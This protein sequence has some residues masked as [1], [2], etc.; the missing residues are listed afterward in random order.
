MQTEN[1]KEK[2][3]KIRLPDRLSVYT[4]DACLGFDASERVETGDILVSLDI[5]RDALSVFVSADKT[6][7]KYIKL[8]WNL[9]E[10]E[11]RR[12]SL[13]VLG[14]SWERA[15]G[16]LEWHS[17]NPERCLPF[18]FLVSNGS[19]QERDCLGRFTEGFG[20]KVQAGAMCFWN[21]DGS[22]ITLW[23]DVRCGGDGVILGGR[24]LHASDIVFGEYRDMSAYEA[25]EHFCH[26]MSP[27]TLTPPH[28]VYGFNNWYYAYGK[29]SHE[30]I[31]RDTRLAASLCR[32]L[33]NPPYMVIDDGWQP[34]ACDG[35]WDRGNERFPD[36]AAL[37]SEIKAEG[38]RP[39]IWV[40]Y[41]ADRGLT[42]KD[43][44]PSEWRSMR[45][46]RFIDPSHPDA[47]A[48]IA[49]ITKRFVDWGYELIKQDFTTMDLFGKRSADK[50]TEDGW[51]FYDRS[52]TSAEITVALYRTIKEAAGDAVVIGCNAVTHLCAGL[53]ELNRTGDDTSGRYWSRTRNRGVN[54][55]AFHGPQ[56]GAFYTCDADCVGILPGCIPW[57]LNRKWLE[58]VS[59]SG[60]P[61]FVS[62]DPDAATDEVCRDLRRA[63]E[64]NSVQVNR[65]V[66]LDWMENV[67]P[68]L[69]LFDGEEKDINWFDADGREEF[70]PIKY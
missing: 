5:S 38:V 63:F 52:R 21:Y 51:H 33:A 11:R 25:A 14:D 70:G 41:L 59:K 55:V 56:N 53:C 13:K 26:V 39:G 65:L 54:A 22:G 29:S 64:I 69:W 62:C 37:A 60:T 61:L 17:V 1:R 10:D 42:Q 47:L 19:D 40:R 57:E 9:S 68:R 28:K 44:I 3:M 66:P 45:D 4:E 31:M 49:G 2:T 43:T 58:L 48:H 8:R 50:I 36:M 20:V 30:Q 12:G 67:C 6:P 27:V 15:Y 16:D 34:N 24:T 46:E 18:Y 23:M 32:G 7:L 35:P